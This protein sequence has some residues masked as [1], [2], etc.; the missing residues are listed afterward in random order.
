AACVGHAAVDTLK[1]VE[2]GKIVETVDR[3]RIWHAQTPQV[4]RTDLY[5]TAL[6]KKMEGTDE[7]SLMELLGI[8]P[9]IVP[10]GENNIKIT[11][12][13]DIEFARFLLENREI[14]TGIGMDSHRFEREHRGLTLGGKYF[15]DAPKCQANS[16]GDVMLHALCN[17]IFQAIGEGS[18]GTFA[19]ALYEEQGVQDSTVYLNHVLAQ[20]KKEGYAVEQ[21]GFQLEG[22]TPRIDP[23]SADL[24]AGLAALL[25]I[26]PSCIGITATTG[27]DLTPF[28]RGEGLQCWATVT[29]SKK[30]YMMS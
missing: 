2:A 16:D 26:S 24:K 27:E 3:S 8:S 12:R 18:L 22:S 9:S 29:L 25:D 7:M 11:T 21:V 14:H 20:M 23:I 15:P 30:T 28:G 5:A 19:D 4:V 10:A 1:R 17:A 13:R 6:E